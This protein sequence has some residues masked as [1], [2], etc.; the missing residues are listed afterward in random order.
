VQVDNSIDFAEMHSELAEF[1]VTNS[2]L[3]LAFTQENVDVTSS[4][5]CPFTPA[6][7]AASGALRVHVI[8]RIG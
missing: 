4:R 1:I 7:P 5:T 6:E 2:W 3:S 8:E